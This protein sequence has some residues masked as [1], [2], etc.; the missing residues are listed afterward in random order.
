[1]KNSICCLLLI[2]VSGLLTQ[3]SCKKNI[4]PETVTINGLTFGCRVDGKAFIADYWDYGNNIPPLEL[5]FI[6]NSNNSLRLLLIAKRQNEKIVIYLNNPLVQGMH[7]L[8]YN[9]RP[10]PTYDPPKDNGAYIVSF[11]YTEYITNETIGGYVDLISMDTV[12][13]KVYAKFEF[14][15]T[16]KLTNKQIKITNGIFKNY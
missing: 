12:T 4:P 14:T 10:F 6:A 15:G 5:D 1:M 13:L 3:S 11:P 2:T 16:D 9:T 7:E 8:K